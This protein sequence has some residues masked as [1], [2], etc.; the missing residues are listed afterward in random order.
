MAAR[1]SEKERLR[2]ERLAREQAKEHRAKRRERR[3]YLGVGAVLL[4]LAVVAVVI[5]SSKGTS[6]ASLPPAA[7]ASGAPAAASSAPS[8]SPVPGVLTAN[9]RQANQILDTTI[10]AKVAQLPGVPVVIN[11]WASWCTN[12]RFE[13]PFF[14]QAGRTDANR[15]AFVGLDSQDS[16]SSAQTFLRQFP[17]DY[18]SVFD[19]S[20]SQAQS[21]GGGQGWPTTIFLNAKHQITN[22]HVGAYPS[23]QALQLDID[24]YA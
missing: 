22:V 17:V 11:Q 13:F 2:Q 4:V 10:Q 16:Q 1:R 20:A 14:Q 24:R 8:G 19:P 5:V 21:L 3:I 9:A 6:S 23:L 15:V 18:P 12:C 7:P